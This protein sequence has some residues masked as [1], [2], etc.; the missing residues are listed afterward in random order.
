[1]SKSKPRTVIRIENG[2][3]ISKVYS[4]RVETCNHVKDAL[5]VSVWGLVLLQKVLDS[6]HQIGCKNVKVMVV[7]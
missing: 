1:M 4:D 5:D 3:F 7:K 2:V 6:L